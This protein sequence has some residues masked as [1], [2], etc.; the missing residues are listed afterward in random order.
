[1]IESQ[2][3]STLNLTPYVG[4]WVAVVRERVVGVGQTADEARQLALHNRP[5]EAPEVF[6]VSVERQIA[7]ETAKIPLIAQVFDLAQ[8][9]K[10]EIYL[11]GGSVRDLLLGRLTHDL[12]F[13]VDGDGLNLARRIA[14]ALHAAYVPIDRERRTGR[15]VL[16]N[17]N[18]YIDVAALRGADLLADLRD[19]D[20]TLNAIALARTGDGNWQLIDPLGGQTDLEQGILRAASA[21]SLDHDPLRT[22]RAVRMCAQFNCTL[23][24]D[25]EHSLRAAAPQLK[26]VSAER[27]RDEWFKILALPGAAQAI[28]RLDD[29][30]LL[31]AIIPHFA[32]DNPLRPAFNHAAA[33]VEAL[34]QV[35]DSLTRQRNAAALQPLQDFASHLVQRYAATVCDERS[36]LMLLKCAALLH[37]IDPDP[38]RSAQIAA[39]LAREWRCSNREIELLRTAITAQAELPALVAQ[40]RPSRRRV[41][42]F[43]Q[44]SGAYGI[45]AALVA[46]A[47]K[48]TR[49]TAQ[50][51]DAQWRKWTVTV[52]RLVEAY[53]LRYQDMVNPPLLLTGSDLIALGIEPGPQMGALLSRLREEQAAGKIHDREQAL[54]YVTAQHQTQKG[55][56]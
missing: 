44:K 10:V 28:R 54:A 53:C 36:H 3:G 30:T 33:T 7:Q 51:N 56:Q 55:E 19:R 14:N 43:Y 21:T 45:D 24:P 52:A 1:M 32:I 17:S 5:K 27:I 16:K 40:A 48:R 46:L 8:A 4:R 37:Q 39:G 9:Y 26:Q 25:T 42:R 2:P 15:V 12:D 50:P 20:F 41:Y 23:Y 18:M 35:W 31:P 11:V 29:L 49:Y 38:A 13:A 34:E 6:F 47:N 22:M